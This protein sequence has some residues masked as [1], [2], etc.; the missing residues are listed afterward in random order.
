MS[1][2][3][4]IIIYVMIQLARDVVTQQGLSSLGIL[5]SETGDRVVEQRG[6]FNIDG[7]SALEI[8]NR[9]RLQQFYSSVAQR[10]E[11]SL[12]KTLPK[13]VSAYGYM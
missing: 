10:L 4:S 2:T 11:W 3:K 12:P 13:I 6:R 7:M 1:S 5:G 9:K 8:H